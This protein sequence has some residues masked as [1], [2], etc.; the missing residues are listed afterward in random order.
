MV[1]PNKRARLNADVAILS[2]PFRS[3]LKA[4]AD[5]KVQPS[6]TV[7]DSDDCSTSIESTNVINV[8]REYASLGQQLRKLRQDLDAVQQASKLHSSNQ[9]EKLNNAIKQWRGI[10]RD[11]ADDAF[12]VASQ[13]VNNMGGLQAWKKHSQDRNDWFDNE[14][15]GD[16]PSSDDVDAFEQYQTEEQRKDED[17]GEDEEVS[18]ISRLSNLTVLQQSFNMP[19]MLRQLNIDPDLLG[20]DE[21]SERWST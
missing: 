17:Q 13:R 5:Q 2:R 18:H 19:L 15:S 4:N 8:Q 9:E 21:N 20:F 1:H 10:A 16:H 6:K 11:A 7:T 14:N 12:I 3:P